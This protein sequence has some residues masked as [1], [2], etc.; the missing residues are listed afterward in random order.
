MAGLVGLAVLLMVGGVAGYTCCVVVRPGTRVLL[1]AWFS[2]HSDAPLLCQD[3]EL[4][5]D[6]V[7]GF[8]VLGPGTHFVSPLW[9]RFGLGPWYSL[10]YMPTPGCQIEID[11]PA[12]D[13]L[14]SDGVKA[15]VDV[16]FMAVVL[17]WHIKDVLGNGTQFLDVAKTIC[18]QWIARQARKL[19]ADD[20]LSYARVTELL[21]D[22]DARMELNRELSVPAKLKCVHVQLEAKSI[23]V[24][25]LYLN[26]TRLQIELQ[27]KKRTQEMEA[28][29]EMFKAEHKA[30]LAQHELKLRRETLDLEAQAE[31]TRMQ[32]RTKLAHLEL[33][34][35]RARRKLDADA[36]GDRVKALV[37]AGLSSGDASRVFSAQISASGLE[38]ATKVY[39][40]VTPSQVG[41]Q[42]WVDAKTS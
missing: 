10:R 7:Q 19:K 41:L 27:S 26:Q 37:H 38:K 35:E 3:P 15:V 2:S 13:V 25:Q 42:E 16:K 11:P 36:L 30:K 5:Q 14:S 33:D 39:V 24:D 28:Q 31:F 6:K 1:Y 32:N 8:R 9:S 22:A 20:F 40:G 4:G 23:G 18:N 17:D 12:C 29:T 21:N 34:V